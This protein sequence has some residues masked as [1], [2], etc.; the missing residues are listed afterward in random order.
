MGR[1]RGIRPVAFLRS[2]IYELLNDN[3]KN[4]WLDSA[5]ELRWSE[6]QL[7]NL[8][9]FRLA[10]AKPES[11]GPTNFDALIRQLFVSERTRAGGARRGRHV[12][13]YVLSHTLMRPRDVISYFRECAKIA[14]EFEE[15]K[16]SPDH[17]SNVNRIYSE[18]LRQEIVD[19][20][21][22]SIPQ[23]EEIFNSISEIRKQVFS[24]AELQA[25]YDE[26]IA[27]GRIYTPLS[28]DQVC[29]VL[30]HFSAIGNQPKQNSARLFKYMYPRARFNRKERLALHK[31]LLQSLQI[32]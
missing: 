4:K 3:D 12:F 29:E 24:T 27:K 26:A 21:Q 10:R 14:I 20:I 28:F 5:L 31:G 19:E 6:G 17:F 1:G 18:R 13:E 16:I 15:D 32:N 25:R 2:D 22:G 8:I 9:A 23:I 11:S 7:R 30:F